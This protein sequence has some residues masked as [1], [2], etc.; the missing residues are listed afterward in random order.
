MQQRGDGVALH[1]R[2]AHVLR[3]GLHVH[4][5]RR[6]H[7]REIQ[8]AAAHRFFVEH[9][10]L[11]NWQTHPLTRSALEVV[12]TTHALASFKA[13]CFQKVLARWGCI[14]GS[15]GVMPVPPINIETTTLNSYTA[16]Q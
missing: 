8:G 4:A 12:P 16:L 1:T 2:A 11:W 10:L 14:E 3:G 6:R 9:L 5:S 13:S 15:L 7:H